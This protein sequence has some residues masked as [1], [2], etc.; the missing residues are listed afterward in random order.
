MRHH[1][2]SASE[3]HIDTLFGLFVNAGLWRLSRDPEMFFPLNA[4][5]ICSS[6]QT[7]T[8]NLETAAAGLVDH[9]SFIRARVSAVCGSSFGLAVP[10]Q[11]STGE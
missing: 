10:P 11:R 1:L 5:F 8:R 3:E 2:R 4:G 7:R 9:L 6:R